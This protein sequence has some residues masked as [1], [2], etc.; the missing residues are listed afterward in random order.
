MRHFLLNKS[1][2]IIATAQN[3]A[4]VNRDCQQFM[5]SP[6]SAEHVNRVHQANR[7]CYSYEDEDDFSSDYEE[8]SSSNVEE[9]T[10]NLD[11]SMSGSSLTTCKDK[12]E[13]FNFNPDDSMSNNSETTTIKDKNGNLTSSTPPPSEQL[14]PLP[15]ISKTPKCVH[16]VCSLQKAHRKGNELF[17]EF[18]SPILDIETTQT[19]AAE[20]A[21]IATNGN[22]NN[23]SFGAAAAAASVSTN[24]NN[25]N[26]LSFGCVETEQQKM[27]NRLR[28]RERKVAEF[29]LTPD[30][31][32]VNLLRYC[33]V[34]L[35]LL[36]ENSISGSYNT[37]ASS[38]IGLFLNFKMSNRLICSLVEH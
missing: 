19:I 11:D 6:A 1:N 22:S 30:M 26:N 13:D 32:L 34:A 21:E 28:K 25:N 15:R 20:E 27:N 12:T 35:Q 5:P 36:P 24:N 10:F 37:N 38:V 33:V 9:L 23:L 7:E 18:V 31:S 16:R 29:A 3:T 17:R 4:K 8:F 14:S 2:Y